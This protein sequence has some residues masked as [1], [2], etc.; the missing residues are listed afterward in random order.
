M[1]TTHVAIGSMTVAQVQKVPRRAD[2]VSNDDRG[3]DD[4]NT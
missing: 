2:D 4:A 3:L 1:A